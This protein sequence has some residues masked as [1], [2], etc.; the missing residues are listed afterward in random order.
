VTGSARWH[1]VAGWISHIRPLLGAEVGV[2]E[3]RFIAHLLH[4]YPSLEMYAVDPWEDQPGANEDYIGWNWSVIY[5]QY[6]S[7]VN[8]FG[9]RAIEMRMHSECAAPLVHV[10]ALDF[11]FIDAQH[12]YR[13]VRRDIELWLPKI[14]TGGLLCGHDYD[15]NFPGVVQAVDEKFG[16]EIMRG[17]NAVWGV[18][19]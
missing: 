15:R 7:A 13:S 14:R 19:C 8:P 11:A 17:A 12:D 16:D 2:K 10:G 4:Q 5:S 6:L 18:W 1:V 3:G 9:E